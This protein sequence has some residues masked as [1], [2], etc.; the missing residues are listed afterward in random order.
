MRKFRVHNLRNKTKK[1]HEVVA[2]VLK[3]KNQSKTQKEAKKDSFHLF[4][5]KSTDKEYENALDIILKDD[6]VFSFLNQSIMPS[7]E[8]IVKEIMGHNDFNNRRLLRLFESILLREHHKINEINEIRSDIEELF[9]KGC[10]DEIYV[11]L[12]KVNSLVGLSLWEMNY[13]IAVLTAKNEFKLIDELVEKWKTDKISASLYEVIR[14][15]GWKSHSVEAS[16]AIETMVRRSNKEYIE[17]G[18]L[19]IAAFYSLMCLQYPIYDDVDLGYSLNWLQKMPLIDLFDSLLKVIIYKITKSSFN[20]DD[21]EGFT[22]LIEKIE[23]CIH[24]DSLSQILNSLK[25]NAKEQKV[26]SIDREVYEYTAGNYNSLLDRLEGNV[27]D[28]SNLITKAN[29]IAKSYIYTSRR[30]K[31]L[32]A[33]FS[34]V[35]NNLIAIYSLKD[36]N[37]AISQLINLSI[38]YSSLELSDHILISIMKA[39]PFYFDEKNKTK[40]I[41]KS[42]FLYTSLTPLACNL[43]SPP[44]LYFDDSI[45]NVDPLRRMKHVAIDAIENYEENAINLIN[46]YDNL[47]KIRKDAIELKVEYYLR[48][49]DFV[50]LIEYA[51]DVLI[52]NANSNI[53]LPLEEI[54]NFID[55]NKVYSLNS[56]IC[57]YYYNLYSNEDNS[58]VINEFFEEFIIS[59]GIERPSELLTDDL[60]EKEIIFLY[61]ISKVD[62]MD[63]LGCFDDDNDLKIERIKILNKLVSLGYLKQTDIDKEC[64]Y[65]VD[66]ILID[67]EAARFNNA[68]IF[69]DTKHILE[70]RKQEIEGLITRYNDDSG[71]EISD[72]DIKYQIEDRTILKGDKNIIVGRIINTLLVEYFNNKEIGL[73]INLSSEIR[74]GFFSNLICSSPQSK[75]LITELDDSGN[76]KSNT[77]W[78]EYYAIISD[79]ILKDID[80]LLVNFSSDFNNLIDVAENWMKTAWSGDEEDRVFFFEI[81]LDEFAYVKEMLD[82][83]KTLEQISSA[84][85]AL[86]NDKLGE[87]L[88]SMKRKLNVIFA[89]KIDDL[90]AEL[91][92]SINQ[93]KRGASMSDLLD[94]IRLSNT[95]VKEHIRT[96]CEWF[97]LKKTTKL[98]SIELEKLIHLAVKCFQQINNCEINIEIKK[99]SKHYIPGTHLYVLVLCLINFL[100][101]S[102]KFSKD[103]R[104]VKIN[105][106][107]DGSDRFKITILN[108]MSERAIEQVKNGYFEQIRLKLINMNDS[109]LLL[110]NGGSGLY[111]CLHALKNVSKSYS[112]LPSYDAGV[113]KVEIAY[114]Y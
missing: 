65:I 1:T 114:G 16:I 64:K 27:K 21:L 25:G 79:H 8:L 111:K 48:K 52:R 37:Q 35:I 89:A 56:V 17:G 92:E 41:D 108:E 2:T 38:I 75:H 57:A 80:N 47:T 60:S 42:K 71:I 90:Y 105:I 98:E 107:G 78:F 54:V 81:S 88:Y 86:F 66:G 93:A 91:I 13:R 20:D 55:L 10:F 76:Y 104:A 72:S 43:D 6:E 59:Q 101:N 24:L 18:A 83:N 23:S 19:D 58:E 5:S 14:V 95:E 103:N 99:E 102:Y 61:N 26:I 4:L 62:V 46:E 74:H 7:D 69:V 33:L 77:Y 63:Y 67:S 94:E 110:N 109:D 85:F 100:N 106:S 82:D 84:I 49:D 30:P 45:E 96:V 11:K 28:I 3:P 34:S 31:S 44:S 12:N 73:D 51:T 40:I 53:C 113:F 39:A 29:I 36:S 50:S 22:V 9:I 32:P 87:C 112:L 68:K 70:K 97:S 15:C